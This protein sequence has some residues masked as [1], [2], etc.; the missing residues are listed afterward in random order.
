MNVPPK[1]VAKMLIIIPNIAIN[2]PIIIARPSL[3]RSP[4]DIINMAYAGTRLVRG[5]GFNME[6]PQ[7]NMKMPSIFSQVF[8]A[9]NAKRFFISFSMPLKMGMDFCT[10]VAS[11]VRFIPLLSRNLGSQ[12]EGFCHIIWAEIINKG[13][14]KIVV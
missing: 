13:M 10:I 3:A 2:M 6:S 7:V 4:K 1:K 9:E 12:G 14:A 5:M 11:V 8:V